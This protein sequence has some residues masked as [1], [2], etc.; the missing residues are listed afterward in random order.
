MIVSYVVASHNKDDA[1][2]YNNEDKPHSMFWVQR[3]VFAPQADAT[4]T[5]KP[6]HDRL[7]GTTLYLS[8]LIRRIQ[9]LSTMGVL[10]HGG[11]SAL[12]DCLM[13]QS[14]STIPI[15]T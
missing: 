14:R 13:H 12:P 15:K 5:P 10:L 8:P 2:T 7:P 4:S 6:G 3:G 11:Q 9:A 1:Y